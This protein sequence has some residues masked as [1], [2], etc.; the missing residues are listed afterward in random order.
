MITT[1]HGSTSSSS[2]SS[3]RPSSA[4]HQQR[5]PCLSNTIQSFPLLLRQVGRATRL[6]IILILT[7]I[8]MIFSN[9]SKVSDLASGT[10]SRMEQSAK[11]IE[12]KPVPPCIPTNAHA[13]QESIVCFPR[14]KPS[15]NNTIEGMKSTCGKLIHNFCQ[16]FLIDPL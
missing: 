11:K 1:T 8:A 6:Q 14:C 15:F 4:P 10:K 12:A 16:S 5:R 7:G 3:R 9:I 2:S 13:L